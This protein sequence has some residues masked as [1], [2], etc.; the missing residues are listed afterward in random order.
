MFFHFRSWL[1]GLTAG[2]SRRRPGSTAFRHRDKRRRCG[3]RLYLEALEPRETPVTGLTTFSA[4]A[5][6]IDMGQPTQTI[7]NALKPYGLVYD[8]VT[9]FKVPVN[10]AINPA[11]TTFR[12]D[13]GDPIPVDFTATTTTGPKSYSGGSFIIDAAFLTPAVVAEINTWKAQ[14]VVV[15]TLAATLPN[16]DIFGQVTSFPRAVL[17]LQNGRL[18]VPY[19]ANAG[20]PASSYQIGNPTDLDPC[21]DVYILPH[22]DP[23]D[24]IPEWKQAL[25]NFVSGSGGLWA[26]CH[27]V[28]A[29]EDLTSAPVGGRLNFL[30]ND[31]IPWTGHSAGTPPYSYNS[32][33]ANDP[34][35]QIMNRLDAATQNGSEQ[36][37]VP[38]TLDWRS[39]TTV[40]VF[41]PDHPDAPTDGTSPFNDAAIIAYGNAFGDP[42]KG[43]VMY[44]AGH[45][46]AG[47][48]AANIAAQRAFFNFLLTQGIGKAPVPAVNIPTIVPGQA[49]TLTATFSGGSGMYSYQ[50][51][52]SN[53]GIFSKPA[54]TWKTG[55][56]PITT[57]Y[58]LTNA[59]DTIRLLV[60]DSCGRQGLFGTNLADAPPV[61]DLDA[62]N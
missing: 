3:V 43:L 4:G 40:A 17:D 49:A 55:D 6:L 23:Q 12:L 11:K 48:A 42:L 10:W 24:W 53:G 18:A 1:R 57:Q 26:G 13:P 31:L 44:E 2:R 20:V 27:S 21:D 35:M 54:G 41:D 56:P 28:S 8:M 62:N 29:L 47:T 37:Y 5:Y 22:A 19:Y 33:A 39:T 15:D 14:G 16:V 34:I 46:L 25:F 30:S 36:I 32:V 9:N 60:T 51:T 61:I 58:L 38:T 50:W 45:S 59:R 52:S 7:G